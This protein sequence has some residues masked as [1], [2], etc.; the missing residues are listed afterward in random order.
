VTKESVTAQLAPLCRDAEFDELRLLSDP[1]AIASSIPAD[2]VDLL[3]AAGTPEQVIA[4]L[5]GVEE[6]GADA[7]AFVPVGPH[8]D[9]QLHL[10]ATEVAPA[11]RRLG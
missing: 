2:L 1:A 11:L 4:S 9:E 8:P 7:I 3:A 6:T 5:R 10:L